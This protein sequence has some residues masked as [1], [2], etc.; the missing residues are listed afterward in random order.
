M[1]EHGFVRGRRSGLTRLVASAGGFMADTADVNV[2]RAPIDTLLHET[3]DGGIDDTRWMIVGEPAP[4]T[5]PGAS[6]DAGAALSSN[7]DFNW[8]SGVITRREFDLS[9]GLTVEFPAYLEFTGEHWQELET[10]IVPLSKAL[11]PEG[12]RDVGPRLVHLSVIGQSPTHLEP[13]YSCADGQ[14]HGTG[15][16]AWNAAP[17]SPGWHPL[18][19]QIR[20][21]ATSSAA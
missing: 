20:P 1:D 17:L 21:M 4:T 15:S 19:L 2:I 18:A 13:E 7:G 3:W 9:Q 5:V 11:T 12:E 10:S 8:P 14:A 6:S 16:Q